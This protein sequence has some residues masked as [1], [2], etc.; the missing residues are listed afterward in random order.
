MVTIEH[1][2]GFET[3]YAHLNKAVVKKGQKVSRGDII[4]YSG[5]SGRSS[6]PH[7]HYEV[8]KNNI[9]QDPREY[10]GR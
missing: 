1:G 7:L 9:P 6:G 4:A 2:F 5:N 8:R 10:I 3:R